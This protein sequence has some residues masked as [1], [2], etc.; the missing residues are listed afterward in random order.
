MDNQRNKASMTIAQK[1]RDR[2]KT[3]HTMEE[4]K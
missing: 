1:K 3:Q 2:C 4:K